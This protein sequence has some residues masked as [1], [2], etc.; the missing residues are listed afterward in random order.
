M[1]NLAVTNKEITLTSRQFNN[2][3]IQAFR[4]AL[5]RDKTGASESKAEFIIQYW[6]E[7]HLV[8]QDQIKRDVKNAIDTGQINDKQTIETWGKV[9][10]L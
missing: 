1:F 7:I 3:L 10:E 9:L 5:P 2:L 4:Y 6:D 8:F